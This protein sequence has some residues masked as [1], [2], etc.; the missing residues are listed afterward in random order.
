M[1][2]KK[3]YV[4]RVSTNFPKGHRR[5]GEGTGFVE[6]IMNGSKVTTIRENWKYWK[7]IIDKINAG[8]GVL[9][10][11]YWTGKPFHSNQEEFYEYSKVGYEICKFDLNGNVVE[12]VDLED[13][14]HSLVLL[15]SEDLPIVAN[16]D[17]LT[18]EDFKDWFKNDGYT[19]KIIIHFTDL[20]YATK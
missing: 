13:K 12:I 7:D 1:T 17:G 6:K 5:A 4:L 14:E 8:Q 19:V 3:I 15:G 11:R 18:T 2:K 20:R 9:S 10:L 16:N